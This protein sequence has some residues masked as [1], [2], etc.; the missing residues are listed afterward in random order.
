M[1]E[2]W[3]QPVSDLHESPCP[4][5]LGVST[6]LPAILSHG[7]YEAPPPYIGYFVPFEAMAVSISASFFARGRED[8]LMKGGSAF[9]GSCAF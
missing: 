2:G 4:D 5:R 9:A 3:L 8:R 6:I 7:Y 1:Q